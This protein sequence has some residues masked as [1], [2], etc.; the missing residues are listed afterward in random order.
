MIKLYPIHARA[1]LV[2]VLLC[3]FSAEAWSQTRTVTGKLLSADDGQALPG[4]SI[5]ESGTTN[6]TV[7]DANGDFS[8]LVHENA[9]LTISFIG[10]ESQEIAI[11]NQSTFTIRLTP[12][13]NTL[14]EVVVVGYGELE[15]K[16]VTGSVVA[17][18]AKDFNRGV[19]GSPQD[20]LLGKVAGVQITS[21]GGAPGSSSTIR[22]RGGSSMTASNDP[23]IVID[24]FPVD[25]GN[26]AGS[27]N[28]LA[29]INPNDIE[30]FT[31]LKDAS[32]TAIYGSRASNGVIIVTTKKS[33]TDK[34]VIGYNGTLSLSRPLKYVDVLSGDE[35][36]ALAEE[37]L[38]DGFSGLSLAAM[39]RLGSENTDWQK[40]IYHNA[41]SQDHSISFSGALKKIPYRLSYGYT[42]QQGILKG[43]SMKRNSLDLNIN[44]SLLDDH[45]KINANLKA[46]FFDH[47]FGNQGAV[48]AAVAYD[49]TQPV[50]N[51]NTRYG[52][53]HTW[54]QLSQSLPDGSNN[55]DGDRNTFGVSNPVALI[56]Q[57]HDNSDVNRII[58]NL[59]LDYRFP[60]LSDLR[61]NVNGG[62]DRSR[63]D[64]LKTFDENNGFISARNG[65]KTTYY[66]IRESQLLDVYF[67][68]KRDIA[69]H[70]I[71]VTA[72]YS[73]QHFERERS[74][75]VR[76]PL[77]E[78][79][80]ADSSY[81]INENFLVSFFGRLVY[82]FNDKYIVTAT[83]RNDGSSRFSEENRWGFFPSLAAAWNVSSEPFFQ[84]NKVL[85]NLKLR[86]GYG[87]TGQQD[88][89]SFYPYLATYRESDLGASYQFGLAN[90][91]FFKTLRPDP[92]D[93][94][95]KW[96][97]TTTINVGIDFGFISDR[98][99]G[100]ID[101]YQRT[102]DDLLNFIPIAAGSNFSNFLTTNVGSLENNGFE[103]S[104]NGKIIEKGDVAWSL[105]LNLSRNENK[106]TKLTLTDDPTYPGVATGGISGGLGNNVQNHQVGH[107]ASSFY[108]FE[109]IYDANGLPI[110]GLYVDRTGE[111]GTVI[112]NELNK[113]HIEN[114]APDFMMGINSSVRYHKFDLY[115]SGRLSL[116]NYVYN[117]VWSDRALYSSLY[118]QAGFWNNVPTA[119]NDTK[120]GT[121]QYLSDHYLENASFFKMDNISLGYNADHL[122]TEKL[123]AR[124][125]LTVQNAFIITDYSGLDPELQ[126]GID[127]NIYPRPQVFL[128]SLNLTY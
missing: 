58:G 95:I 127:N 76:D 122:F 61:F 120:F 40:E 14:G 126:N 17:V 20:L 68:Y 93:A 28:I 75:Y 51:G 9:V 105:G 77:N 83:L 102:T 99:T 1:L 101:Y 6:G 49:P 57:T 128:F 92:Y 67:N 78:L 85:S 111:G 66:E 44:P 123:K 62:F 82:S 47:E 90:K 79:D 26:V 45:L 11:G 36:R 13:I 63:G 70:D 80:V 125:S 72:G 73:W 10:Y 32:A 25:N 119:V 96:E 54:T 108:L 114:P 7:T 94:N 118:N 46:S 8:L 19:I 2:M 55:P 65:L 24:G 103:V 74:D 34:L 64:G 98:L 91:Q 31:V 106:I 52:G 86:A 4:A 115:L 16:D 3:A 89:G 69:K 27:P 113:R 23:L 38:E 60:F 29:S 110:E 109:Q 84:S 37:L 22:I 21:A 48:G 18:T 124:F 112:S 71:D 104:L 56:E 81:S 50:R 116:G 107:P 87:V 117:N 41:I 39:N 59:Q 33:K 100:S 53:Y 35:H 30:S 42:D 88:I 97:E 5:I 43:T 15:R 12:D 121:P